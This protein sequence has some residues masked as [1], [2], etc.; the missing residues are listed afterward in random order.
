MDFAALS[1]LSSA[2]AEARILH[3][4]VGL[5]VFDVL[6]SGKRDAAAVA[7]ALDADGRATELLLNALVA[8]GLLEKENSLYALAP[9]SREY[10][11]RG[12]PKSFRDMVRFESSLWDCWAR[13]EDSIR[14][15]RPARPADMYQ[16]RPEETELFI[17][18]MHALVVARGDA[19]ILAG[20]L[21]L[22]GVSAMLDVGSG[23]GTY[24]IAL[25]RRHPGLRATLFD[26]PATLEI[27][28]RFVAAAG[29]EGRITLVAGDYRADPIPGTYELVFLSNIIHA[30]SSEENERLAAKLCRSLAKNGRIVIKDHILQESRAYPAV[31]AIFSLLMLLT[32]A[33]GR[34]Y[35]FNEVK[36]WLVRA[37]FQ[38]IAEVAL[39][40]PLTS[41]LVI[42]H[43][44]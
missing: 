28:R 30:E 8:M 44:R 9:V 17:R 39:P 18:A 10:L 5:G 26:L 19:E 29:L 32:T 11:L 14:S 2:H 42:G 35:S 41:S 31:G 6:E 27:T 33:A 37:G 38:D 23:P 43:K 12:S 15:G 7:A 24:P 1:R 13:L 3:A 22:T 4:A 16:G 21:D 25:C 20:M 40:A 36:E 34:C